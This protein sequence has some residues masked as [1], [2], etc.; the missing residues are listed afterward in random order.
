MLFVSVLNVVVFLNFCQ[1]Y[2][3]YIDVVIG[4]PVQV[5]ETVFHFFNR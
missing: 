5:V 3:V 4:D 2:F 1:I